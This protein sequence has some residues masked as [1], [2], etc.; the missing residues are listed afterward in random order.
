ME[1]NEVIRK[2][3][4]IR[5]YSE[6]I[7]SMEEVKKCIEAA[8]FAPSAHNS[9]PWKFFV[10]RDKE[11]IKMLSKTQKYSA[12]LEN[13]PVVVVVASRETNHFLEDCSCAIM[14]FML[15]AA[16]LGL[17]TCWNAVY[18]PKTRE[19]EEYVKRI[20]GIPEEYRIVANIGV[21]YPAEKPEEKEIKPL[22][23][24]MEVI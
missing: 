23:E 8:R 2:R 6:E 3:R 11:K 9:Q 1:L 15:K 17:G 4:S 13:A 18:H 19:R 14:L 12:F 5:L 22:E 21:G 7:P 10:V 16:E 20:L 24:I